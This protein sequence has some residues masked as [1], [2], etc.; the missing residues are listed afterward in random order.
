MIEIPKGTFAVLYADPPWK[1]PPRKKGTKFGAGVHGHYPTMTD[2]EIVAMGAWIREVMTPN[3]V[4][5]LWTTAPK[6]PLALRVMDAWGFRY[7]TIAFTWI[8]T[9]KGFTLARRP[10]FMVRSIR[11]FKGPGNYTAS[12]AEICLLGA[13]GSLTPTGRKLVDS[14]ILAPKREHSRKPDEAI[15]RIEAM[16]PMERKLELFCRYP[17]DGWTVWGNEV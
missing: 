5:F 11:T 7:S 4:L 13:R 12:N 15:E 1:Y 10:R 3:A 17:R 16:Y 8:K 9:L 6:L 14:V 2:D